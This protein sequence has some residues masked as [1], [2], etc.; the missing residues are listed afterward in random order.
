MTQEE[1]DQ[2]IRTQL[3]E[4]NEKFKELDAETQKQNAFFMAVFYEAVGLHAI[5]ANS[6]LHDFAERMHKTLYELLHS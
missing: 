1:F 5:K 3:S 2:F 6:I 4:L